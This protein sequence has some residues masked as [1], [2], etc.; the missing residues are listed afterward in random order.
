MQNEKSTNLKAMKSVTGSLVLL[1]RV[2]LLTIRRASSI[3]YFILN[4]MT[5]TINLVTTHYHSPFLSDVM[6]SIIVITIVCIFVVVGKVIILFKFP[7]K[8]RLIVLNEAS[9]VHFLKPSTKWYIQMHHF[10]GTWLASSG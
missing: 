1:R 8:L 6:P 10:G 9:F 2:F 5:L 7:P 3:F 4:R